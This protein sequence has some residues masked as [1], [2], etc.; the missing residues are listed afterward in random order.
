[1]NNV[2]SITRSYL[3]FC[4]YED[5]KLL[6]ST[7]QLNGAIM[8]AFKTMFGLIFETGSLQYIHNFV[9]SS[10]TVAKKNKVSGT[11]VFKSSANLLSGVEVCAV[12][13]DRETTCINNKLILSGFS[14]FPNLLH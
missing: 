3:T 5:F 2:L 9:P 14:R 8:L 10:L 7:K 13:I 12:I 11:V 6:T 4:S 1:M